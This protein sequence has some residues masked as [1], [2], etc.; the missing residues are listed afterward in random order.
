VTGAPYSAVRTLQFQQT[1]AGGNVIT[2][3]EQE[4]VYRDSQG[5]VRTERTVTPPNGA[6]G[7]AAMTFIQIHDPVAGVEYFLNPAKQTVM[8]HTL[9]AANSTGRGAGHT[10]SAD[11]EGSEGPRGRGVNSHQV[12]REEL[13]AQSINGLPSTGSRI[14]TTVPAGAIGNA[15]VIQSVREVWISSDLK[16]PVQIKSSDPRFGNST[17]QLTNINR[18]EP[19]PSLFQVPAG[20]TVSERPSGRASQ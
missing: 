18:A 3:T 19:D 5:R 6:A 8:K 17:M 20:Y 2:R 4:T 14:T 10:M 9:P 12:A 16:V 7:Q 1:L 15:Q 13:G 11:S